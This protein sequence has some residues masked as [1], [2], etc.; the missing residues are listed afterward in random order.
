MIERI[1]L[2]VDGT[3][4]DFT[5]AAFKKF[6]REDLIE[7]QQGYDMAHMIG[8]SNE[9]FWDKIDT[10]FFWLTIPEFAGAQAFVR[11][12]FTYCQDKDIELQYCSVGL[13]FE[14]YASSRVAWLKKFNEACDVDIP[15]ILMS[16][17]EDKRMLA[18]DKTM[19]IDDNDR[20]INAVRESGAL[21]V[22]IPQLWNRRREWAERPPHYGSLMLEVKKGVIN[23][24]RKEFNESRSCNTCV[25]CHGCCGAPVRCAGTDRVEA[26]IPPDVVAPAYCEGGAV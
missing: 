13:R 2:D 4:A 16:G 11:D 12:L 7:E 6:N 19:F 23:A 14:F 10:E 5:A 15:V 17:S 20:V 24:E 26:P 9:E 1:Y 22:Q 18:T 21:G 3:I 8:V 25:S